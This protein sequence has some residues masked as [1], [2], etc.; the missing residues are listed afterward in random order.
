MGQRVL[1]V[2]ER[3]R[4]RVRRVVV[5]AVAAFAVLAGALVFEPWTLW[6]RSTL[7]ES[8]PQVSATTAAPDASLAAEDVPEPVEAPAAEESRPEPQPIELSRGEFITQ[9]HG[10]TGTA[11]VVELADG[12]RILRLENFSTSNGPDLH[13]WLSDQAAGGDWFK[14]A[15]GRSVQLGALKAT[16]GNHNYAIPADVD[17]TGL[18]SAVIW[19]VRF[20]VAFGSAP[21]SL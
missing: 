9:E 1:G 14:Y 4:A 3:P 20:D 12:S 13:V 5:G 11:R 21:L 7:N 15:G 8:L 16:D 18:T 10:T 2:K 17:L 19:C 6:T